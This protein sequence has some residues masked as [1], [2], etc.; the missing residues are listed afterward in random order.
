MSESAPPLE[1]RCCTLSLGGAAVEL[2]LQQVRP[3]SSTPVPLVTAALQADAQALGV[4]F[5]VKKERG[6]TVKPRGFQGP[7]CRDSCVEIFLQPPGQSAYL[8]VECNA[9]GDLHTSWISNPERLPQGGFVEYRFLT[10]AEAS[11][12]GI[13]PMLPAD[14]QAEAVDW[15]LDLRLPWQVFTDVCG[16]SDPTGAWGM[17]IYKCA[18]ESAF[19]HWISWSPCRALNFHAPEDF[20]RLN[21]EA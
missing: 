12:I 10:E 14:P 4:R 16:M 18:D 7:V 2:S 17:N 19:P 5:Q 13:A 20:G 21:V 3:E 8:N 11:P 15:S 9:R 6:Y 1:S